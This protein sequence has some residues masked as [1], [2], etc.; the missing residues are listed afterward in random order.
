[1]ERRG[2]SHSICYIQSFTQCTDWQRVGQETVQRK[3]I[4]QVETELMRKERVNAEDKGE[5]TRVCAWET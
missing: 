5:L 3:V 4:F 1:M 2:E